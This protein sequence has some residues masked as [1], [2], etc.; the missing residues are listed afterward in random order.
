MYPDQPT[1][2]HKLMCPGV[3]LFDELTRSLEESASV[4]TSVDVLHRS[5][6]SFWHWL[7]GL[8]PMLLI[9]ISAALS[10]SRVHPI[11]TKTGRSNFTNGISFFFKLF[12]AVT[13]IFHVQREKILSSKHEWTE[14]AITIESPSLVPSFFCVSASV[15]IKEGFHFRWER[16]NALAQLPSM[17][18]WLRHQRLEWSSTCY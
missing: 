13:L 2:L 1:L 18:H 14:T 5:M 9:L 16:R 17:T 10:L 15:S 12:L 4:Y 7:V 6:E 3:S 11:H 8:R